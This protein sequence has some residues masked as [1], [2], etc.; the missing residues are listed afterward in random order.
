MIGDEDLFGY[1]FALHRMDDTGASNNFTH[2]IMNTKYVCLFVWAF[3]AVRGHFNEL[4]NGLLFGVF[5]RGMFIV[6]C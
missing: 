4:F 1:A 5:A 2:A 3:I 6:K